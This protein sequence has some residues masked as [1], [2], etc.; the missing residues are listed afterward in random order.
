[1]T[2]K[3]QES[4]CSSMKLEDADKCPTPKIGQPVLQ[5]IGS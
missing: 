3:N 5:L 4:P 1:M 2:Y